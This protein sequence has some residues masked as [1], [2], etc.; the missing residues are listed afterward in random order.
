MKPQTL[1][2]RETERFRTLLTRKRLLT[3]LLG[4]AILSFGLYNIHRRTGITEGGIIGLVLLLDHHL[5]IPPWAT[6]ILF[7]GTCYFLGWR[8]LGGDFLRLSAAATLSVA[9][10]LRFW[11]L[12][13][14]VLPDLTPHPLLAALLGG[15]AV[16]LGCGLI[17]RQGGSSGGDDALALIITKMLHWRISRSYLFT[18]VTVLLLSLTYIPLR[19]IAFS[20]ITVTVSSFLID[21][22]QNFGKE[23]TVPEEEA[24]PLPEECPVPAEEKEVS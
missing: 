17:V 23:K 9:G 24:S 12:F 1:L 10:F 6:T 19:R 4:A 3:I 5:G 8:Y 21:L 14:P 15:L 13:P 20:L 2:K 18:D 11:E 22:I 7:D 16:G